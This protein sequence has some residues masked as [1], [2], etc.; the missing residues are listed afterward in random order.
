[1]V[2]VKSDTIPFVSDKRYTFKTPIMIPKCTFSNLYRIE[3]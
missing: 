2:D 3:A 1:M